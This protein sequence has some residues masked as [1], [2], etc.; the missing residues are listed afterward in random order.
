[1]IGLI[2]W[3]RENNTRRAQEVAC[4]HQLTKPMDPAARAT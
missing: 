2:G 1:M 4:D 3:G